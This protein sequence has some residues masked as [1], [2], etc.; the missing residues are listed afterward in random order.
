MKSVAAATCPIAAVIQ[1]G[2]VLLVVLPQLMWA[3]EKSAGA[4]AAAKIPSGQ[5]RGRVVME[6]DGK[7]VADADVRL[8]T[9]SSENS[10]YSVKKARSGKDG[11]FVFDGVG[12]G[13]HKLA[14]FFEDFASRQ[15]RYKGMEVDSS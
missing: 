7:P 9:W 8:V 10:R 6:S 14:A 2:V 3:A 11:E 15:A 12:K 1:S 5:V 13:Q 4:A